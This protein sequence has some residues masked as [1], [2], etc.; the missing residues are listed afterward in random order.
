MSNI[1][2]TLT[3]DQADTIRTALYF[4]TVYSDP[5][6]PEVKM[7]YPFIRRIQQKITKELAKAK[8]N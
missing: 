3:E 5:K 2:I 6:Y 8:L 1:T 7:H 4:Y